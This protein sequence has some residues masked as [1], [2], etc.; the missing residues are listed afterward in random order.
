MQAILSLLQ[1]RKLFPGV[2]ILIAGVKSWED[3]SWE[4]EELLF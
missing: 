1:A 2:A 4:N 3:K